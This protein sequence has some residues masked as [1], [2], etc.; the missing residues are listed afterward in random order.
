MSHFYFSF[1]L[2]EFSSL[3]SFHLLHSP[4]QLL[5][6]KLPCWILYVLSQV[7]PHSFLRPHPCRASFSHHFPV[8]TLDSLPCPSSFA[9]RNP[10][11][12]FQLINQLDA[13]A[14]ERGCLMVG[15]GDRG[16]GRRFPCYVATGWEAERISRS[17]SVSWALNPCSVG[18]LERSRGRRAVLAQPAQWLLLEL[19]WTL[20]DYVWEDWD[21]EDDFY[22][23]VHINEISGVAQAENVTVIT[24]CG[25]SKGKKRKQLPFF[26]MF[27]KNWG[28]NLSF[29]VSKMNSLKKLKV[30][31]QGIS[32]L[33]L[34]FFI[35]WKS[36]CEASRFSGNL[37]TSVA[38]HSSRVALLYSHRQQHVLSPISSWSHHLSF[39]AVLACQL[40][41]CTSLAGKGGDW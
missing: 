28:V 14:G 27:D 6:G 11:E 39:H 4:P 25:E 12:T 40:L 19:V 23:P 8:L 13:H 17:F 9:V 18:L 1:L 29:R 3:W 5:S 2:F 30:N 26:Y 7:F 31:T 37:F 20:C 35:F 24:V 15:F 10:V 16:Q 33:W 34:C 36:T 32:V 38:V 21:F 41:L 22:F